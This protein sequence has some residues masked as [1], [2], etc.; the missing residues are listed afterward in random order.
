MEF[1]IFSPPFPMLDTQSR[2]RF[3]QL[4]C[5]PKHKRNRFTH[6]KNKKLNQNPRNQLQMIRLTHDF[7][8]FSPI[9]RTNK[10]TDID[11]SSKRFT[12]D[13]HV[14]IHNFLHASGS[15]RTAMG[16]NQ[17]FAGILCSHLGPVMPYAEVFLH[18]KPA[19]GAPLGPDLPRI[20]HNN[21]APNLASAC[22]HSPII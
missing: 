6:V 9:F 22:Q 19:T 14:G 1:A 17:K 10:Q 15:A 4:L 18:R 16:K 5:N 21:R 3:G 8:N 12:I 2:H 11:T 20:L 13:I 7:L